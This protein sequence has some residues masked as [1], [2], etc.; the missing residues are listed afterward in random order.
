M[1]STVAK[2]PKTRKLS[3]VRASR[4]EQST[5]TR[6]LYGVVLIAFG[7]LAYG[8]YIN[9]SVVILNGIFSMFSLMG[10]GLNLAASKLVTRPEDEN[11]QYGYWH[12]EPLV[13]C[14]NSLMMCIIC[15]YAFLNGVE[16]IR[17]GGHPVDAGMVIWFS[18]VTGVICG[19]WGTYEMIMSYRINSQLLR[20]DA[21]EWLMDFSFSLVTLIGFLGLFVLQ[22]PLRTTWEYYADSAMVAIMALLLIPFPI[23]VLNQNVREVLHMTTSREEVL[24]DRVTSAMEEIKEEYELIKYSTHIM[25]LG[26][27]YFVEV[28]ILVGPDFRLQT[29]PEQDVLR[30]KIWLACDKP[31]DELWLSVCITADSRWN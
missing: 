22:E 30:E 23:R 25:K 29:I 17:T 18:I 4:I 20:N 19:T 26:R 16:G 14:V 12:V 11:F 6:S 8:L 7:S 28:N 27:T 24:I 10:S 15:L 2:K 3:K 5:L 13:H 9:S 21:R 31:L 1:P